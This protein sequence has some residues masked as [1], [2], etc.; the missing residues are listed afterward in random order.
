M[1]F[2]HQFNIKH[3]F[4]L[5][6]LYLEIQDSQENL[7]HTNFYDKCLFQD[8][9]RQPSQNKNVPDGLE[10]RIRIQDKHK[11]ILSAW[12]IGPFPIG[13]GDTDGVLFYNVSFI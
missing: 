1:H 6:K 12:L 9:R 7:Y 8:G 2:R 10:D 5:T 4:N 3:N 11:Q 13:G